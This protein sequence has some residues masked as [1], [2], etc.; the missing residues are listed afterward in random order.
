MEGE[1]S[2][3]VKGGFL[4]VFSI[5]N[6]IGGYLRLCSVLG[7]CLL[8]EDASKNLVFW[9]PSGLSEKFISRNYSFNTR[10]SVQKFL[11]NFT[12]PWTWFTYIFI[13]ITGLYSTYK[14][15]IVHSVFLWMA[16][17][18]MWQSVNATLWIKATVPLC[19]HVISQIFVQ[20]LRGHLFDMKGGL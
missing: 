13:I 3:N 12:V 8:S 7:H 20:C 11:R 16:E 1:I 2:Q 10:Y 19:T 14:Y 9:K 18:Q 4:N 15:N 6:S 17:L 5:G